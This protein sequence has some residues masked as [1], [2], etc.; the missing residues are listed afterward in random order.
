MFVSCFRTTGWE[1]LS[2]SAILYHSVNWLIG[3][4]HVAKMGTFLSVSAF[5]LQPLVSSVPSLHC[6][7]SCKGPPGTRACGSVTRARTHAHTHT[8][9]SSSRARVMNCGVSKSPYRSGAHVLWCVCL[10]EYGRNAVGSPEW[11]NR[12][13]GF[14]CPC[15]LCLDEISD[16]AGCLVSKSFA[17]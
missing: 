16:A 15:F 2:F 7:K 10:C 5:L 9:S 6:Q 14:P 8:H 3:S 12:A 17:K 4:D 1:L 11:E 13:P